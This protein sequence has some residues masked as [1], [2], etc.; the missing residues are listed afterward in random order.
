MC[1]TLNYILATFNLKFKTP[2]FCSNAGP[3]GQYR[4]FEILHVALSNYSR[5]ILRFSYPAGIYI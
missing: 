4:V 3:Q 1:T 5:T 2:R